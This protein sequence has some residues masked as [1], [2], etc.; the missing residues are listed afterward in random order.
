MSRSSKSLAATV[1][2]A[3]DEASI[4]E[5]FAAKYQQLFNQVSYNDA[6]MTSLKDGIEVRINDGAC[7][8]PFCTNDASISPADIQHAIKRLNPGKKDGGG[9]FSTDHLINGGPALHV[10]LSVLFTAMIRTGLTPTLMLDSVVDWWYQY[11]RTAE[12]L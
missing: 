7:T 11:R 2:S 5:V 8:C 12:S 4:S 1:D 9:I 6:D 3:C 10:A